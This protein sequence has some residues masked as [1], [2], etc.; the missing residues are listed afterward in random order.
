[1]PEN[2]QKNFTG[3]IVSITLAVTGLLIITSIII[4]GALLASRK[5]DPTWN[6]FRPKAESRLPGTY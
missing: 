2:P 3:K 5:W 4:G 6:P 1:M